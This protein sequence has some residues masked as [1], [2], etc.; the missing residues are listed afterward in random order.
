MKKATTKR[1]AALFCAFVLAF[2]NVGSVLAETGDVQEGIESP[3]NDLT[4]SAPDQ[5]GTPVLQRPAN[6]E[7]G[8]EITWEAVNN[9]SSYIVYR[10]LIVDKEKR[11]F[12]EIATVN[13][14]TVTFEDTQAVPGELYAYT[15]QACNGNSK[16]GISSEK[17]YRRLTKPIVSY[18]IEEDGLRIV[19]EEVKGASVYRLEKV[20]NGQWKHFMN[21]SYDLEWLDEEV[22]FGQKYQ[23]R[24]RA[25]SSSIESSNLSDESLVVEFEVQYDW[26]DAPKSFK[27]ANNGYTQL[28]LTWE[29]VEG[30]EGYR[31]YRSDKENGE[32]LL[33]ETTSEEKYIDKNLVTDKKYYYKMKAFVGDRETDFTEV[34]SGTPK[35]L[36]P[37]MKKKASVTSNSIKVSWNKSTG[38]HGYYVYRKQGV[39]GEWKQ[40]ATIT[41]AETTSYK[42][43]KATGRYY[44][45]V[46][47]YKK[48]NGKTYTSLRANSI[49]SSVLKK[50]KI[51]LKQKGIEQK[52]TVSWTQ[53]KN[54]DGYQVYMKVGKN[55]T[56]KHETNFNSMFTSASFDVPVG[57]YV[58]FK[59]RAIRKIDGTETTALFSDSQSFIFATP[60]FTIEASDNYGKSVKNIKLTIEN[61]GKASLRFYSADAELLSESNK[62]DNR[63]MYIVGSSGKKYN[64]STVSAGKT[65]TITYKIDGDSTNY[66]GDSIISVVFRYDGLYYWL[67]MY[68]DGSHSELYLLE[69]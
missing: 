4:D 25:V 45:A 52:V 60:K 50:T 47:A 42:D 14:P 2:C 40:I 26:F 10:S 22:E 46:R 13:A 41:D 28:R 69:T 8:I 32:F 34:K 27:V 38:A 19:W 3:D 33:V 9:A 23:Y 68:A 55:G 62:N 48:V 30:A 53:I 16:G 59:V 63:Q 11:D 12:K 57:K 15:V 6:T 31:I 37:K 65:K 20:E 1:F 24:I 43:T 58:Y 5:V 17:T 18:K 66:Q 54:A 36:V 64:Y 61:E 7:N 49:Q 56:W 67:L 35:V 39:S 29:P 44:Y 51:T 21:V